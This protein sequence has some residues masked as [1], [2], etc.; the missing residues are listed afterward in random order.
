MKEDY[1]LI[2]GVSRGADKNQIKQAYRNMVKK[3]HP[4]SGCTQINA[5]KFR[6][7]QKAYETLG[8]I[9]R[10]SIYDRQLDAAQSQPPDERI[11]EKVPWDA[12]RLAKGTPVGAIFGGPASAS[13][14]GPRRN[15][16][17]IRRQ[18]SIEMILDPSANSE[19][20]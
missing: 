11:R 13:V 3:Y 4:D 17:G 2:L 9:G 19:A 15:R 7:V 6:E 20:R 8:D 1:Y 14:S 16:E 5:T 18:I 12:G 10:R